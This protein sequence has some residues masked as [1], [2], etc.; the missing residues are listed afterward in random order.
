MLEGHEKSMIDKSIFPI[1]HIGE[2]DN[3]SW[4]L[5]LFIYYCPLINLSLEPISEPK[6]GSGATIND[7]ADCPVLGGLAAATWNHVVPP[8]HHAHDGKPTQT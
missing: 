1:S 8:S 5:Q 6:S 4:L 2:P 3:T 7:K